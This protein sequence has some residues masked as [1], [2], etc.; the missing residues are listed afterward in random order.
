MEGKKDIR[1]TYCKP[2]IKRVNLVIDEAV[3]AACKV[4]SDRA[5]GNMTCNA[6]GKKVCHDPGS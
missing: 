4:A 3:L 1:R 5:Q 6:T 2:Q